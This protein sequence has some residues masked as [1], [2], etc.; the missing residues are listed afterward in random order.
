MAAN[1]K[2]FENLLFL[3]IFPSFRFYFGIRQVSP[4]LSFPRTDLH[5]VSGENPLCL[6]CAVNTAYRKNGTLFSQHSAPTTCPRYGI[7]S[8]P[9]P[10][11]QPMEKHNRPLFM[12]F[13]GMAVIILRQS[14]HSGFYCPDYPHHIFLNRIFLKMP[15]P[16]TGFSFTQPPTGREYA[17][18]TG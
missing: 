11:S 7:S 3:P 12:R 8:T 4:G 5:M 10:S 14:K 18:R 9:P 1:S 15:V 13:H 2:S 6:Q 16:I 17:G